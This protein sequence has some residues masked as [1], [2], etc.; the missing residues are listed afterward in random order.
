MDIRYGNDPDDEV[1]H[2]DRDPRG[3]IPQGPE[4]LHLSAG[5][6]PR[7]PRQL[8]PPHLHGRLEVLQPEEEQG[9]RLLRRRAPPGLPRRP[10]GRPGHGHHQPA[11]QRVPPR[12][13]G[14]VRLLRRLR[15]P[16]GLHG[17]PPPHR[18]MGPGQ[19]HDQDRRP[20]RL[21]RPG[22]RGLPH[23]GLRAPGDPRDV[24]QLR[25]DAEMAR[26]GRLRQGQRLVRLQARRA[27]GAARVLQED[28]RAAR[29]EGGLRHRRVQDAQGD[30]ALDPPR[31]Q[32]HE[33]DLRG[34][35]H[36]RLH[37]ALGGG[38]GRPG[39][40]L[41]ARSSTPAS[42]RSSPRTARSCP[43]SSPCRT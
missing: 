20:L 33:R 41:P 8:G 22:P 4:D 28:L 43:S 39:Q 29:P 40:A 12:E 38:D 21:L 32:P 26:G 31:S 27:Q 5:E 3:H 35:E 42:S 25:V 24:L 6:D 13:D 14:P 18:A 15:G 7:R 16:R 10:A 17:H 1:K 34:R 19:G 23:R 30:Q 36:L 11:L 37:P 9:L 2:G